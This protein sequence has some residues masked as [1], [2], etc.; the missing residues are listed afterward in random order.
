MN[1]WLSNIAGWFQPTADKIRAWKLPPA[2]DKLFEEMWGNLSPAIQTAIWNFL[3]VMY[4]KYGE[5]AAKEL[6]RR[7]LESIKLKGY[8]V[9]DL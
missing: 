9:S 2:V 7:I 8:I 1:K 5:E 4:E 6:L 3:K